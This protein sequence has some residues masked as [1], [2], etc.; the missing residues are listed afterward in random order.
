MTIRKGLPAKLALTDADDTRYAFSGLV[1]CNTSG[2]PRSGV[3]SPVGANLV[4]ATATMNVSVARFQAVAVRDAGVVLLSNDGAANVLLDASPAAN[5]RIDVIY[6]KQ[7]DSSSTVTSPDANDVPVLTFAKGTAAAS[8]VK[9]SIPTGAVELATVLIPS[10]ATATNSVGVVITQT[11]QFTAA[12]GGTVPFRTK[13]LLDAWTTANPNQRAVVLVDGDEYLRVGSAWVSTSVLVDRQIDTTNDKVRTVR[14]IGF[15]K[16]TGTGTSA[17]AE[18]VTFPGGGFASIP[19]INV[20]FMGTRAAG[21]F[22]NVGLNAASVPATAAQV[23]TTTTF[24][25]YFFGAGGTNFSASLD[26]YYSWEAIGEA[27]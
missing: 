24:Q 18:T 27:L 17:M 7:N 13:A 12:A 9:P 14:K 25:A 22:N 4:T 3:T 6:A 2:V 21:A 11:S 8:P 16:I 26:W 1:A 20:N 23:G 15:G 5:S 10:T 19:V